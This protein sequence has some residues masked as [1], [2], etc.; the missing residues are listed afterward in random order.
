MNALADDVVFPKLLN[1]ENAIVRVHLVKALAETP[2][3]KDARWK[4]FDL[5]SAVRKLL[6]DRDA[7]VC[8]AAADA[9]GRHPDEN[10]L[11]A[12]LERWNSVPAEDTHFLHTVR[13]AIRD[14]L[15]FS[16][17]FDAAEKLA[18]ADAAA[19]SRLAEIS[20]A[21]PSIQS[22]T[23]LLR[24][25]KAQ[26][27]DAKYADAVHLI[28]R[29]LPKELLED[30]STTIIKSPRLT[31]APY[32]DRIA[33]LK[34]W[35][36]GLQERGD[37]A[38]ESLTNLA[39]DIATQLISGK[40]DPTPGLELAREM[41]L[42]SQFD[43][44]AAIATDHKRNDAQRNAAVDAVVAIDG[45]KGIQLLSSLMGSADEPLKLRQKAAQSLA[46][47]NT[48]DSRA[49]LVK[50]L[51]TAPERLMVEIASGLCNSKPGCE[52][53]IGQISSGK[54]SARLLQELVVVNKLKLQQYPEL[55]ATLKKLTAGLP[56]ADNRLQKLI[57]ERRAG[58]AKAKPK[59]DAVAGKQVFL[60]T[61]AACHRLQ[62]EG[63]KI[64]PELDG[65][66]IRGIDRILEDVLDPSRNVDLNFRTTN[67]TTS[68]GQVVS[69]LALREEGKLLILADNQGKEV[70]IP[71]DEIETRTISPLSP[72]PANV[73]DLVPEAD[74]YNLIAYL[75]EQKRP[76]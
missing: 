24:F 71:L 1:D 74:F 6:N 58:F 72:M 41:H 32:G 76:K 29:Y 11:A 51:P 60:K 75:L 14:N 16:R 46:T 10:N 31:T 18:A 2:G 27:N 12:L 67:L 63:N 34:A 4:K 5:Y 38:P 55:D 21:V 66:G 17:G 45:A 62:N 36:R 64:G 61:C 50:L 59:P 40:G 3:W 8:M 53:L 37:K 35:N 19:F 69:G 7:W 20:V 15:Q 30:F 44:V 68:A 43:A 42:A 56:P 47:V 52:T 49:A 73:P 28:A 48:D 39:E 25:I 13:I 57:D 23:F 65:V 70:R 22:A 54:A 33:A 26:P 9:L